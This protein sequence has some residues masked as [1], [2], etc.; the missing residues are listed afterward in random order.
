MKINLICN[1]NEI[2][3]ILGKFALKL[4]ENLILKGHKTEI[5]S[6]IDLD[7]DINHYLLY[8]DYKYVENAATTLMI[9]H[10]DNSIKMNFLK[11][12]MINK[13]I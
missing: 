8:L 1:F 12:E 6:S 4:K 2:Q 5:T 13:N 10:I 9:T 3:W 7:A 11:L